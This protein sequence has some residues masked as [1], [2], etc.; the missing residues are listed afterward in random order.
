MDNQKKLERFRAAVLEDGQEKAE[1]ILAAARSHAQ[2]AGQEASQNE[3]GL[4][5]KRRQAV[6]EEISLAAARESARFKLNARKNV[7]SYRKKLVEELFDEVRA[8]LAAFVKSDKYK[9]NLFKRLGEAKEKYPGGG[10]CLVRNEDTALA[11][12]IKSRFGFDVKADEKI[13]IGGAYVRPAGTS[14]LIDETLD[15]AFD[16]QF[17]DFSRQHSELELSGDE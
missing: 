10:V 13:K 3:S 1:E 5:E 14:L 9:E 7:L 8:Q 16:E 11:D 15:S 4:F 12:E 17:E 6:I 2:A